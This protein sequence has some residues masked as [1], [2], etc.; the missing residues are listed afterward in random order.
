MKILTSVNIEIA[1]LWN[2]TPFLFYTED[3]SSRFLSEMLVASIKLHGVV[4]QKTIV[5]EVSMIVK[6]DIQ[7]TYS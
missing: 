3:G 1:I 4:C 5:S 6:I 2:V 7:L